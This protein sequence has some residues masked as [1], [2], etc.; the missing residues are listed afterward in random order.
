[1][2]PDQALGSLDTLCQPQEKQF[3]VFDAPQDGVPTVDA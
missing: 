3:F 2:M 1:M